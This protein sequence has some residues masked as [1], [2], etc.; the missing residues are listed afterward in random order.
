M[1]VC[2]EGSFG[3]R[4]FGL[5]KKDVL[6]PVGQLLLHPLQMQMPTFFMRTFPQYTDVALGRQNFERVSQAAGNSCECLCCQPFAVMQ[7]FDLYYLIPAVR[8]QNNLRRHKAKLVGKYN[9]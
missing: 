3:R 5:K 6:R 8:A 1:C 2:A 9:Q 4:G 7:A